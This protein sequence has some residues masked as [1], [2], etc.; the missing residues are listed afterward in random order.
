MLDVLDFYE[1]TKNYRT[2]YVYMKNGVTFEID[3]YI[4]PK[5]QVFAI[6]GKRSKVN[7]VYNNLKEIIMQ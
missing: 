3:N 2:R 1:V 5:M 6:E 7:K 4:E